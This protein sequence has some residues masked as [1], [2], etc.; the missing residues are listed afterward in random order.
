M[1][2]RQSVRSDGEVEQGHGVASWRLLGDPVRERE[3]A[4]DRVRTACRASLKDAVSH[5]RAS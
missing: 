5:P 3:R 1:V 2:S 4:G